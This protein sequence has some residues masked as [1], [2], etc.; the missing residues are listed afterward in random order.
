[1]A[2][3]F[4][5]GRLKDNV[6]EIVQIPKGQAPTL[7]VVLGFVGLANTRTRGDGGTIR[8]HIRARVMDC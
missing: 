4:G 7:G 8:V 3:P 5:R 1:M 2:T 6:Q